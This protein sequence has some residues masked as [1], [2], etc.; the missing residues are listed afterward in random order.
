MAD[1]LL[2]SKIDKLKNSLDKRYLLLALSLELLIQDGLDQ[3]AED[4]V[5]EVE[6][7]ATS[8]G[9]TDQDSLITGLTE[10]LAAY[11][12]A[13]GTDV[14]KYQGKIAQAKVDQA[15]ETALPKLKKAGATQEAI[16]LQNE[17]KAYPEQAIKRFASIE[18]GGETYVQRITTL[19]SGSEKTVRN[20]IANGVKDGL[21]AE[22]IA[23]NIR[24]YV[25]PL[26]GVAKA[27]PYD[28]YRKTFGK[29]KDFTPKGVP[30]GTIQS[31][32][33]RIARTETANLY[34]ETAV[35]FYED[36]DYVVGYKWVLSNRHPHYDI[37]DELAAREL[38]PKGESV[39]FAHPYCLCDFQAVLAPIED[40]KSLVRQGKLS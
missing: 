19:K 25:N 20:I 27:R 28:I 40:M 30:A 5:A 16:A 33:L 4:M 10:I 7:Y 3:L 34:R 2:K 21:S 14:A 31:N 35:N 13:F 23:L 37:C 36:K 38:Y 15:L 18:R 17:L 32:A 39:P 24:Q 6:G 26:P 29:A 12:L 1:T 8:N 9:I 22:K 11:W